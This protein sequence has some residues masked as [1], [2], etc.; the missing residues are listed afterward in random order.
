[1]AV[2]ALGGEALPSDDE[3]VDVVQGDG[4][5]A[6]CRFEVELDE[7]EVAVGCPAM[8]GPRDVRQRGDQ[9]L[10]DRSADSSPTVRGRT[11]WR[12]TTSGARSVPS[13]AGSGAAHQVWKP[14]DEPGRDVALDDDAR[15]SVT[16]PW[17][18]PM[19]DRG[20]AVGGLSETGDGDG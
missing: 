17:D 16:V 15:A 8:D 11:G 9:L 7:D 13:V 10:K 18:R 3:A 4:P 1:M 6:K 2:Q 5:A 20:G 14:L 12:S 19:A